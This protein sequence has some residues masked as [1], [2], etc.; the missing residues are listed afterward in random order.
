MSGSN[1]LNFDD[2][3]TDRNAQLDSRPN[4][5]IVSG[6]SH[7]KITRWPLALLS[8]AA[9]VL[10]LTSAGIA[11]AQDTSEQSEAGEYDVPRED[12]SVRDL[13]NGYSA[14]DAYRFNSEWNLEKFLDV[15]EAGAYS[16]L[17]LPEFL[18]HAII[19]RDGPV[20]VLETRLDATIGA[21]SVE[22]AGGNLLSLD[23]MIHA[24]DSSVQG[25]M[26]LHRGAIAYEAYPGMRRTDNHVWMSNTKILASLLIG[27]LEDE[28][29]IDVQQT[30]G[31]YRPDARGTAWENVK[32]IDV[33][34][35]QSGLD[36]EENPATRKG[37]TPYRRFVVSEVGLPNSSGV[38]ETHNE[39][40]LAIPTLREPGAA[41]EYSSANTQMLG[42]IVE[43]VTGVRLSEAL[44]DRLWI[45]AGMDGDA[46]LALTPQG[47]GI[48]HGLLSSRLIDMAKT[49]LLYTPS[50]GKTASKR[51]VSEQM[52]ER[53]QRTGIA[54]NYLKG[55]LGP[56]MAE[57]F[58]E[59]PVA[60]AYQRDAV[61]ADGDFYKSGMNDQGI[62]VSPGRDV[63]VVWFATGGAKVSMEAFARTIA[64]SLE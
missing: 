53:I 6:L 2:V 17:N 13:R 7:A 61:F 24:E 4:Q 43:A 20:S 34:N 3:E 26:V 15:T 8:S 40:L 23:D 60:N 30:V 14:E 21:A 46:V 44:T 27:Q 25:V 38:V 29:K 58:R 57:A 47:N 55:S 16:Y 52:I 39:A 1:Q 37:D 49:G 51:V 12:F 35:M 9:V 50:W 42:L 59:T 63:V 5:S 56:F 33:L 62:Y 54:E 11:F 22:D 32:V 48:I 64:T 45:P 31:H 28:G 19:R 41:F 36:L 18:P 10:S